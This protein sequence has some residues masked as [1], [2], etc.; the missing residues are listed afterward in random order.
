MKTEEVHRALQSD[1][2]VT[3]LTTEDPA[4]L[5][6]AKSL[7]EGAGIQFLVRGEGLQDLFGAGRIGT[8]YNLIS[9]PIELQVEPK[10]EEKASEI[11][12]EIQ[13]RKHE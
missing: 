4:I 8:G 2:L 1:S 9:G 7:L 6:Y 11:L 12:S 13:E 3:I 5:A 10:D